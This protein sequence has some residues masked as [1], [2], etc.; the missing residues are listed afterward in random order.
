MIRVALAPESLEVSGHAGTAARGSDVVCAA[1]STLAWALVYGLR[2][3]V[4]AE[5]KVD[6]EEPGLLRLSWNARA[7]GEAGR[8]VIAVVV[9]SLLEIEK[10]HPERVAVSGHAVLPGLAPPGGGA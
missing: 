9:G 1:V 10:R 4:P 5:V 7:L 2:E 6:Q 3:V 8:A